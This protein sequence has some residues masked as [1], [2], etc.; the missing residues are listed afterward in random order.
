MNG[1]HLKGLDKVVQENNIL[2]RLNNRDNAAMRD[3]IE[4]KRVQISE[5]L[6]MDSMKGMR[7]VFEVYVDIE[8]SKSCLYNLACWKTTRTHF[9]N[10]EEHILQY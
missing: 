5:F 1:A 2:L 10:V 3:T 7:R 6:P 4:V 9:G 8:I